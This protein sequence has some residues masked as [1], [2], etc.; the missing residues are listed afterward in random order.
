MEQIITD[1]KELNILR[2]FSLFSIVLILPSLFMN[3]ATSLTI[4]IIFLVSLIV[5]L[6]T[7]DSNRENIDDAF[8]IALVVALF[9]G[10]GLFFVILS[11]V[12]LFL[13]IW[14]AIVMAVLQ[15]WFFRI[16]FSY[17]NDT[18]YFSE[19]YLKYWDKIYY[20]SIYIFALISLFY[21]LKVTQS[22]IR[23]LAEV[24]II[25]I[26]NIFEQVR[27]NQNVLNLATMNY[28][29]GIEQVRNL[30]F[31]LVKHSSYIL[32]PYTFIQSVILFLDQ[33]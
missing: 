23:V 12:V 4:S 11:K 16:S 32:L 26:L 10:L 27:T 13:F 25:D 9:L 5:F 14:F 7:K 15:E 21:V 1:N 19:R 24:K 28:E 17:Y 20:W 18:D 33:N 8:K 29:S 22:D 2:Y 31:S 30:G 3:I 6:I